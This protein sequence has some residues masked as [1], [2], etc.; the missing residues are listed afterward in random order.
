MSVN[1]S[2]SLKPTHLPQ[3]NKF[4]KF[5]AENQSLE[6]RT[7]N[8]AVEILEVLFFALLIIGFIVLIGKVDTPFPQNYP[9]PTSSLWESTWKGFLEGCV[10]GAI[11]HCSQN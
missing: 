7:N 1:L 2:A 8:I 5:P 11:E 4:S 9:M 6:K 3:E 10:Q